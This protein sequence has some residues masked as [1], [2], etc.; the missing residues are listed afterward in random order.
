MRWRKW[1]ERLW[2]AAHGEGVPPVNCWFWK[3]GLSSHAGVLTSCC[4]IIS[5]TYYSFMSVLCC[6]WTAHNPLFMDLIWLVINAYGVSIASS[7]WWWGHRA[8]RSWAS[9]EHP[10]CCIFESFLFQP[11]FKAVL[12]LTF[13]HE[14]QLCVY[15]WKDHGQLSEPQA[16]VHT[17]MI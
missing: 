6:R 3:H 8:S 5:V 10:S 7:S 14:I 13:L 1:H 15:F 12:L 11:A 9:G 2:R 16:S 17:A 4:L